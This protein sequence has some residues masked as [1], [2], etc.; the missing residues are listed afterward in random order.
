MFDLAFALWASLEGAYNPK[1]TGGRAV[2]GI[3]EYYNPEF[4]SSTTR[5]L[6]RKGEF[7]VLRGVAYVYLL[8]NYW[9][10]CGPVNT[11]LEF[12]LHKAWSTRVTRQVPVAEL[13]YALLHDTERL[14]GVSVSKHISD[15]AVRVR[16]QKIKDFYVDKFYPIRR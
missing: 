10:K 1:D 3:N 5:S 7:Q 6:I 15:G 14:I 12:H 2:W 13:E 16:I 11:F 4:F 9:Y 8:Q